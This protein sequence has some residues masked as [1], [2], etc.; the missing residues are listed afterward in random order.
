MPVVLNET[1]KTAAIE[2]LK[3]FIRHERDSRQ[4]KKALAV[5]LDLPRLSL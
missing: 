3:T 4:V 1:T 2:D 5:K